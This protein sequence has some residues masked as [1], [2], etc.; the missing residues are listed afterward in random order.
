MTLLFLRLQIVTS[1]YMVPTKWSFF[2]PRDLPS[3]YLQ[4]EGWE[5]DFTCFTMGVVWCW[6]GFALKK[7]REVA[8]TNSSQT[9]AIHC[10]AVFSSTLEC[11]CSKNAGISLPT[12][13]I[14]TFHCL[15]NYMNWSDVHKLV[16][17]LCPDSMHIHTWTYLVLYEIVFL[18]TP[19]H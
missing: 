7:P 2:K 15:S 10:D 9:K 6:R 16:P 13:P 3:G 4:I 8:I 11:V 12:N 1:I 18:T 5:K 14:Q 19:E 17:L